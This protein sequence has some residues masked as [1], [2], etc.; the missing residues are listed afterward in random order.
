MALSRNRN[1]SSAT[2]RRKLCMRS[3]QV[4]LGTP[5]TMRRVR[6]WLAFDASPPPRTC[7]GT[8]R[9]FDMRHFLTFHSGNLSCFSTLLEWMCVDVLTH[10]A[11][12]WRIHCLP[13][14]PVVAHHPNLL[15]NLHA[16]AF[17]TT[18]PTPP[19]PLKHR[20]RHVT[21]N[22]AQFFP[23]SKS[24]RTIDTGKYDAESIHCLNGRFFG[25]IPTK[26][27]TLSYRSLAFHS[28]TPSNSPRHRVTRRRFT[29]IKAT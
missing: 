10:P 13:I 9:W 25:R 28:L 29:S 3:T 22:V 1:Q 27:A 24:A 7:F 5:L 19:E 17:L 11:V 23:R 12:M 21:G 26:A 16:R 15:D 18:V 20:H 2:Y 6:H 8:T 14:G 4:F